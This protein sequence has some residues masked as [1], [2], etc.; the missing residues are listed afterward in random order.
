MTTETLVAE[1][2]AAL[3]GF[4]GILVLLFRWLI[5]TLAAKLDR[6]VE[7][8]ERFDGSMREMLTEQRAM[9]EDLRRFAALPPNPSPTAW[10]S[11]ASAPDNDH[12]RD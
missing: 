5:T 2:V 1:L 9:R 3:V 10:P 7:A 6:A 8:I 11:R 4:G 12:R